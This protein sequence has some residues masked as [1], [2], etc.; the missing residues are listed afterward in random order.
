MPE[1][2]LQFV[3]FIIFCLSI[4]VLL[5]Y[6][7]FFFARLA[8]YK[9][10]QPSTI[11][12]Q[13]VSVVICAK[14]ED[15]NLPE[16]LP[17]ILSQDYPEYEVVVVDD[18]SWDNTP[19]VL[20]EFEKKYSNLKVI[21]IKEDLKHY[22]G[23]K[24]ALMVG[25]KGASHDYLLLTDGDCKPLS[26]QWLK[27]M[28]SKFSAGKEIMLGYSKYEKLPGLLNKLIRFDTFHIAL[29]YFSFAM[30][31]KPYMGIGRNLAYKKELFFR[32]KGFA[33][34]YHIESGDDDLFIN[35]AATEKNVAVEFSEG[36]Y[37]ESR[38]KKDWKGWIEQKRRHLTTW[39]EYKLSDKFRLGLYPFSQAIFWLSFIALLIANKH[40]LFFEYD[41]YLILG[42]LA[43][44]LI[45]QWIIFKFALAQL[46]EKDLFLT[47]LFAELFLLV[48][49][50]ALSISNALFRRKKWKRI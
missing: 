31:G 5:W 18:C 13:P 39:K 42:L 47:S 23:K 46:K 41:L 49:Y 33:T 36:S 2:S 14:N 9:E 26:N 32:H 44:R 17:L 50:P 1:F 4:A 48:F 6:Y 15:H 19:D 16:F 29:Q 25:I 7:F 45:S 21:T 35:E 10:H 20:R 12:H 22:H 11:N 38:V 43:L 24:F 8:F 27:K 40:E 28:M 34:H 30:A 37:T 3:V